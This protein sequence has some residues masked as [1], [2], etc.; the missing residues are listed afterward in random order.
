VVGC[1]RVGFRAAVPAP[2]YTSRIVRVV[3]A[4]SPRGEFLPRCFSCSLCV[5]ERLRFDPVGQWLLVGSGLADSTP[6][7]RGQSA[8]HELLADHPRTWHGPSTCRGAGWVI[9]SV[10]NGPSAVV[11]GLSARCP[12]TVRQVTADSPPG[13]FQDS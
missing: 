11:R 1:S 3:S 4:D 2:V 9:L 6:G 13:L 8:Q 5:L 7:R 12:R 10:F